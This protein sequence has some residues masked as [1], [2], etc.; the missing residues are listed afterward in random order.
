MSSSD[1]RVISDNHGTSDTGSTSSDRST[2]RLM[3][4]APDNIS[5]ESWFELHDGPTLLVA[6]AI[7]AGWLILLASHSYV[8]WWLTAPIAGYVVQWHFSLQHEAIHSLRRIPRWLRRALVSPPIGI[9]FPFELYRRS[10]SRHHRDSHLTYPGKDTETYYHEEEDWENY[11]DLSRWLLVVNQTFLGRLYIGPF[12]RTPH[13]FHSEI[14]K[15]IDGDSA[16][17][18]I[19]VRHIIAV[20]LLLLLLAEVFDMSALQYLAEFVYP[21]L[22]LGMM[23]SFTEHRWG[24]Q[25]GERTAVVESNWLFGLLF[26]WN[27]LHVVHH[28]FPTLPWWK[29]P[30]VWRQHREE[31]QA[32]NGGFVFRGYG[33]IA[34]RWLVTPN[35]IPVHPPSVTSRTSVPSLVL[36]A[37]RSHGLGRRFRRV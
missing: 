22:A 11:G 7:Y 16:N 12:L 29:I 9:W 30:R 15:I 1:S 25:P 19:W 13:F 5:S 26:L 31:I 32:H 37:H 2:C 24:E 6:V 23:R 35:F 20:L 33:E 36:Q 28:A 34:R 18:G 17:L 4:V 10:H 21:G 8:P 27:N 14:K 3:L